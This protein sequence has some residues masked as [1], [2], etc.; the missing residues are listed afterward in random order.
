[1]VASRA[2][3]TST[4]ACVFVIPWSS[5]YLSRM[6]TWRRLLLRASATQRRGFG[7][8]RPPLGA[9]TAPRGSWPCRSLRRSVIWPARSPGRIRPDTDA[10]NRRGLRFPLPARRPSPRLDAWTRLND[11]TMRLDHSWARRLWQ[12]PVLRR[13]SVLYSTLSARSPSFPE[14]PRGRRT[15]PAA[16]HPPMTELAL[17]VHEFVGTQHVSVPLGTSASPADEGIHPVRDP[18]PTTRLEPNQI[19]IDDHLYKL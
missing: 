19:A 9:A 16:I 14:A 18:L 7:R 3:P 6:P 11:E 8:P 2:R 15:P 13:H 1:M 5:R 17:P 12:L 4:S 10:D